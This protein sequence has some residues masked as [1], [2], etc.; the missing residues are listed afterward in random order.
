MLANKVIYLDH[1]ATTSPIK[2]VVSIYNE[3]LTTSFYNPA[4]AHQAGT[5]VNREL[6]NARSD[7]LRSFGLSSYN[8]IFTSGASESNNLALKGYAHRYLRRGKHIIT[9]SFEHPSV[10][11]PLKALENEGF[12]VTYLKG[13]DGYISL[14]EL[15]KAIRPDTILVSIMAVNNEVGFIQDI[16]GISKIVHSHGIKLH[17]DA[18]QA[19]GKI[20]TP[21]SDADLITVSM[22]KIGGLKSSGLLLYKKGIE[23]T[24]LIDG[25]GQENNIRSGTNDVPMALAD[26]FAIK[27]ALSH[28]KESYEYCLELVKP[29]YE[30][31]SNHSDLYEINSTIDNPFIVNFSFKNKKASVFVEALSSLGIMVASKSACSSR[32]DKGSVTLLAIGKNS[33]L[34][35]NAIRLSF[36]S[37]NNKE[38]IETFI[39]TLDKL[40]KELRA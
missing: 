15:E 37:S 25:G 2:E 4:S 30:Y 19:V 17:I 10:T 3:A 35:N 22:H 36:S 8:L 6:E 1:A 12:E 18:V 26:A 33:Q 23:L 5:I 11:N 16:K 9:S 32:L 20:A 31:L 27:Y 29:L 21:Y 13:N 39:N 14:E 28:Q 7:I 38:D 40:V 24:S 34:A